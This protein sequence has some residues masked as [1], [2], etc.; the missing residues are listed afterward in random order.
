MKK[1]LCLFLSLLMMISVFSVT[2]VAVDIVAFKKVVCT[3]DGVE[4]SWNSVKNAANYILYRADG[5]NG[6]DIVIATTTQTEYFDDTVEQGEIYTY[7]IVAQANDGS[8]TDIDFA[9]FYVIAF[10][11]PYCAHEKTEWEV[12]QPATVYDVG[13]QNN[14][15]TDCGEILEVKDIAQLTPETPAI[16]SL[17]NTTNGVAFTW[18]AVDGVDSYNVYRRSAG[19]K[20][21]VLLTNTAKT[22]FTD[23]TAENCKY[24]KYAV[25]AKNEG[26]LSPYE[27]GRVI[28][29]V[30]APAGL[31]AANTLGGIFVKWDNVKN[32][33]AYRVYRK[34]VGEE[35]WTYLG[36]TKKNNYPDV[37]VDAATDYV[38]TVR[39]VSGGYYS[40]FY[41]DN[42][43]VRRLEAPK[44]A[45][46]VSS[47]EGLTFSWE[48]VEG[49]KGYFVYR[50]TAASTWELLGTVRGT[51]STAY[52]DKST[53][54]GVKYTYTVRAY[55]D[56]SISWYDVNGITG[57][58]IH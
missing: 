23:R 8:F 57:K 21:W 29:Y 47:E 28:K 48:G 58:D 46:T 37:K 53:T 54:K 55:A 41:A 3:F 40:N 50:K 34:V 32:I 31:S 27:G 10:E 43:V 19:K 33:D 1:V 39:A 25:R 51:R 52:L 4:L 36:T 38:Y 12:I 11:K 9:D 42:D 45:G 24:Y 15:C 30:S 13:V 5:E 17:Y 18:E 49:A 2:S 6:A 44:L 22:G 35:N 16:R 26:G 20:T 56:S 7:K 14:V